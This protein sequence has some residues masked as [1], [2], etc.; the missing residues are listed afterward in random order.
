MF[1]LYI[2]WASKCLTN[3]F[4]DFVKP[5]KQTHVQIKG[6]GGARVEATWKGTVKWSF[7]DNNEGKV[8]SFTIPDT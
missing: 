4:E 8:H 2:N 6:I 5:P 7:K 3:C 1:L